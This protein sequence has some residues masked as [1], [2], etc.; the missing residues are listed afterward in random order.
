MSRSTQLEI[1][2]T[3]TDFSRTLVQQS[4]KLYNRIGESIEIELDAPNPPLVVDSELIIAPSPPIELS[5]ISTPQNPRNV[6][7]GKF[8]FAP[9]NV[10]AGNFSVPPFGEPSLVES[11][12]VP[13]K[14]RQVFWV[15]RRLRDA[16]N[17]PDLV[18]SEEKFFPPQP[19]EYVF[20]VRVVDPVS[21][22]SVTSFEVTNY[23]QKNQFLIIFVSQA[24]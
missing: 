24:R 21:V 5:A 10:R 19:V 9:T 12:I 13:Q 22:E 6:Q 15:N 2:I 11:S 20:A 18:S 3:A 17:E 23:K 7:L 4:L 8:S 1:Q 14:P 16:P